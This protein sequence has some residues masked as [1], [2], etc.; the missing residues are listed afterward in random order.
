MRP[1]RRIGQIL[2]QPEQQHS[3]DD[4]ELAG[5]DHEHEAAVSALIEQLDLVGGQ[6]LFFY[7][8]QC[9]GHA[10]SLVRNTELYEITSLRRKTR[11][12]ITRA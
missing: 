12:Q 7:R 5:D 1:S 10:V 4:R 3:G 9:I 11:L 2:D 6:I 8:K